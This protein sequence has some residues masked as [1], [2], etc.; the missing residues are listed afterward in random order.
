[1]VRVEKHIKPILKTE[2]LSVGYVKGSEKQVLLNDLNVAVR[3]GEMVC[4][5]GPNGSGKSTL[6]RT[7]AGLHPALEGLA[8]VGG[9]TIKEQSFKATARLLSLVLTDKITV[10]NLTV[11]QV[12][13]FGRYPYNNWLGRITGTDKKVIRKALE[14]VHLLHYADRF[15]SELSDGERQRT[16]VAKALAQDTPFVMLDEPTAHLDLPNRVE[17]MRLLRSLAKN[18]GKAILL[19]THELDLALQA[20]DTI[21]LLD[22]NDGLVTGTPEDLVLNGQF[23]KAFGANTFDFDKHSGSFKLH[24][25]GNGQKIKLN[26]ET[27]EEVWM[28][29]ALQREGYTVV[30]DETCL[31][32]VH[33]EKEARRW[34]INSNGK[35]HEIA[36]IGEVLDTLRQ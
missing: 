27:V 25:Q 19:S 5:I 29:R 32:A 22:K 1:M 28:K 23:E 34:V 14:Q 10:G 9:K 26:L 2:K 35:A 18:T 31:H 20:A 36:N 4:M 24:H 7:I 6:M 17:I 11:F 16:L 33:F 13:S 8:L 30:G 21:W 3:P 12:V 15:V